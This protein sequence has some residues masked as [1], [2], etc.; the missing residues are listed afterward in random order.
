MKAYCIL[1]QCCV[2]DVW[3]VETAWTVETGRMHFSIFLVF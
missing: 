3:T 1:R 2:A